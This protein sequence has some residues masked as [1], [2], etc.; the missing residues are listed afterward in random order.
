MYVNANEMPWVLKA[1]KLDFD[2]SNPVINYGAGF[3]SKIVQA[4]MAL[5]EKEE[6][7]FLT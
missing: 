7:V 4:V 6:A 1:K 2:S 3:I 5:I